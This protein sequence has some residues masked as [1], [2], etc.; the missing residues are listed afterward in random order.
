MKMKLK[1]RFKK[2]IGLSGVILAL[3][4]AAPAFAQYQHGYNGRS[5]YGGRG[6]AGWGAYDRN[7]HWRG[8]RWWHRHNIEW[9]YATHPEWAAMDSQWRNEDGD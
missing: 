9:F 8:A 5:Y 2:T 3:G 7:H 6:Q 1:D 4:M